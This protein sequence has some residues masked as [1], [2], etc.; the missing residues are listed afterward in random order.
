[1]KW[2]ATEVEDGCPIYLDHGVAYVLPKLESQ[3]IQLGPAFIWIAHI[4]KQI[5]AFEEIHNRDGEAPNKT[6][7]ENK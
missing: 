6:S 2:Y 5:Q 7:P 1:M 3:L 4:K